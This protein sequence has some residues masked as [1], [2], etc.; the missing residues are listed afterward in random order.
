[1][2][3]FPE[4]GVAFTKAAKS[5][6]LKLSKKKVGF[7]IQGE[8]QQD[9]LA[10][11][12][13]KLAQTGINVTSVQGV[14]AGAGRYAGMLCSQPMFLVSVSD[15]ASRLGEFHMASSIISSVAT[16]TVTPS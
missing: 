15:Q 8:D 11:V 1:M 3:F 14:S 4:N 9:A 16:S 2:D 13:G 7:L 5:V 6:G 10:G 12:L